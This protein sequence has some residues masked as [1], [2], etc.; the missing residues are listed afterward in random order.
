M[1][2]MEV[3]VIL[4]VTSISISSTRSTNFAIPSNCSKLCGNISIQYPF[5]IED[6]CFRAGF[7]L[8]CSTNTDTASPQLL[9]GD[10]TVVVTGFDMESGL[11]N[12]DSPV[13]LMMGVDA[14]SPV[15]TSLI[16]LQ[17]WPFSFNLMKRNY[18]G[19]AGGL[20]YLMSNSL[21][22]A[23]C[24]ATVNLVDAVRNISIDHCSTASCSID[25]VNDTGRCDISLDDLDLQ[26]PLAVQLTRLINETERLSSVA[27]VMYDEYTSDEALQRFTTSGDRAGLKASLAWYMDDHSTCEEARQNSATYACRS[28]N[29]DCYDAYPGASSDAVG[30]FCRCSLSY[31][32]NPYLP[33]GCQETKST[34]IPAND[35]PVECGNV[36]VLYPFGLKEGCYR[37]EAFALTCNEISGASTLL[38]QDYVV[39]SISIEDGLL[40]LYAPGYFS[41]FSDKATPL[42]YLR[43]RIYFS[44]VVSYQSCE[45]G[46]K[47][48]TTFACVDRHSSCI[49]INTTSTGQGQGYRCECLQ[50]Y[51]GNP[52]INNGCQDINECN[53]PERYICN[54]DCTN[55]EGS[56]RCT[57]PPGTSGDPRHACIP[58]KKQTL[59]LGAILGASIGIGLLLS[60]L[61]LVILSRKWKIRKQKKIREKNF[62]QNH[63]LLLQQ[64]ISSSE[65]FSER[66][67]I[68]SLEELAKATN[69]FDE[70]R[71]LGSGGHGI[72]YKGILSDLRVV[73]I[74]K[75]KLVDKCEIDQFINEVAVLS[76]INHRNVVRLFGC[77]LESEVPLLVYEF[78]TNGSLLDHL[79]APAHSKLSW[80]D[81][82][83]IL[84][85]SAGA[86]S[87]LHSAASISIFHRDIK[88]S[89]ILLDE[90]LRAKVSD[91]GASRFNPLNETYI[92]TTVQG[93]F[94]YLDPE[95]YQ[96]GLFTEKSDVYSFG[97]ILLELLTGKKPTRATRIGPQQNLAMHFLEATKEN[98]AFDLVEDRVMKEATKPELLEFIHLIEMCLSLE[99]A[100]RPTMKEV[101]YKLQCMRKTRM[102][103]IKP[104]IADKKELSED[105][106]SSSVST[107]PSSELIY[108]MNQGNSRSYSLEEELM[109]SQHHPR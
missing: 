96:T 14:S 85:E 99:S 49:D 107:Y 25:A 102:K 54:G 88:S 34:F 90:A 97:V 67:K 71:V 53:F 58:N 91:F 17:N 42:T 52:Y 1:R 15:T 77:C 46:G 79:H 2:L 72:V 38:Y 81:R 56:F 75:S 19:E 35:C 82:L 16:N 41:Y 7:N 44:W 29:S 73:A 103:K 3:L 24:S 74:K 78:I 106:I 39:T 92:F 5:G 84:V 40:D 43:E 66:T 23:G 55:T 59:L 57:C 33:D 36:T 94:G 22:A 93:T 28:R 69:N 47:N 31:E 6:G 26:T 101:E 8:T 27:A 70:S 13:T 30:Y 37:D 76:Q 98:R 48:M 45:D 62:H 60:S 63:G 21:Y 61:L 86:I 50:G 4:I 51:Q 83:R 64:L 87:Y 32:G 105:L 80:D 89:N 104:S 68:F 109:R 9:L 11:V 100:K 18:V 10:G 108:L 12:I 20:D 65:Y 95:Y